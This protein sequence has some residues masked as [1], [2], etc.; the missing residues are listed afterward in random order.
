MWVTVAVTSLAVLATVVYRKYISAL[1]S[2]SHLQG[3]KS[4]FMPLS[5]LGSLLPTTFWNPGIDW[6]WKWRLNVYKRFKSQTISC[7]SLIGGPTMI[8]TSSIHVAKQILNGRPEVCKAPDASAVV[9]TLWGDNIVSS[10]HDMY[11]RH[12]RIVGPAFTRSAYVLVAQEAGKLYREMIETETWASSGGGDIQSIDHHTSKFALGIISRCAFGLPFPWFNA[13]TNA[14]ESSF[15][16]EISTVCEASVLRLAAPGW[17]WHLPFKR[18]RNIDRAFQGVSSF[19]TSFIS[20]KKFELG[21][22]VEGARLQTQDLLTRLVAASEA[23]GK[24]GLMDQ[25]LFGNVFMFLLAG[26]E[27]TANALAATL[28]L[29]AVYQEEQDKVV[30]HIR[31]VLGPDRQPTLDDFEALDKVLACFAEASRMYTPGP[32]AMRDTTETISLSV[33]E[34]DGGGQLI[35]GPGVRL[36]VDFVGLHYNPRLFPNPAHYDPSR[37]H[38]VR[39]S[40]LTFF[41]LGPRACLGRKFALVEAICFLSLFL[42]DW[43]VDPLLLE[44]ETPEGWRARCLEAGFIGLGFGVHNV[45]LR[46]ERRQRS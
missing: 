15:H 2:V 35:V 13:L 6:H 30:E 22:Q 44:G 12:R 4:V 25:E 27:T 19:M 11:K 20:S 36:A 43:K 38:G 21:S 31:H 32:L 3:L 14:R 5:P 7:I 8:Y 42:R 24:N 40:D 1:K 16:N 37:W 46:I 23:E 9:S 28:G 41:G 45:P 34:E 39:E 18:L 33:P 17:L 26:H 10:E 29:L